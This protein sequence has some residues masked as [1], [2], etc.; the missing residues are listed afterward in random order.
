[1]RAILKK[2]K[3]GRK[4]CLSGE[5]LPDR[6]GEEKMEDKEFTAFVVRENNGAWEGTRE[7]RKISEL[8]PGQVLIRVS[9]S[10]VNY[11]DALS[12]SGNRGVTRHY[13]HTP[14]IDAAG[15]VEES[16]SDR[17][18]AGD[19]VIVT[20]YDLGMNTDG[21]WGQYIRVPDS[22]PVRRPAGM[23]L[24]DAM[25]YGTAGFTAAL[26]VRKLIRYGIQP[27]DGQILVTGA[28][29]GVGSLALSILHKLGYHTAAVTGKGAARDMLKHLGAEEVVLREDA[30]DETGKALLTPLWAA[31]VDTVGG[32]VLETALKTVRYGGC[33]T[34]CG[35]VAG[36][37]LE[38]TVYPFILRGISLLGIDSVQCPMDER[39]E[40]WQLLAGPWRPYT[41]AENTEEITPETL[42]EN[43]DRILHGKVTGRILV[44]ME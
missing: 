40:L 25:I 21:G 6:Q 34:A 22:W 17:F 28:T 18:H 4:I 10:S 23:T 24:R 36:Y 1:M 27:E 39:E 19:E 37:R 9:Y 15:I 35:N 12:A 20:G 42:P 13:P 43:I 14:G 38:T 8:P 11:K 44:C 5:S 33:V 31:A 32:A 41:F 26:S 7:T 16:G 29:G 3:Q 2:G 30:V